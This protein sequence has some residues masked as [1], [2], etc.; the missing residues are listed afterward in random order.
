M[1]R[2][3]AGHLATALQGPVNPSEASLI[4]DSHPLDNSAIAAAADAQHRS[5]HPKPTYTNHDNK[6][7]D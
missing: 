6:S 2:E 1:T 3:M 7:C 5:L 4:Q